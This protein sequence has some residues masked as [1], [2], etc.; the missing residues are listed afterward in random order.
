M[1]S[2]A[3]DD[4]ETLRGNLYDML[5]DA[6]DALELAKEILRESEHPRAVEVY[7]GLLNNV[8]KLNAQILEL[9]KTHK[10]ITERKSYKDGGEQPALPGPGETMPAANVYI[11]NTAD[12]QNMIRDARRQE[13]AE[14]A[15][16]DVTPTENAE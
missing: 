9:S 4:Y 12:L 1:A 8:V 13:E 10:D 2:H 6:K 11:G 7:S 15:T 3:S 16:I 14:A 5:E